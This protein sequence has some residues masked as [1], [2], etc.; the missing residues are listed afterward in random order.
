MSAG[1]SI[2]PAEARDMGAILGLIRELA[3]YEHLTAA[4]VATEE[5]LRRHLTGPERV[6]EALVAEAGAAAV[7][8]TIVGYAIYFKTFSTFL[9][10]PGIWLEDLYVQPA[11][12]ARGIG[13]ALLRTL[14][15]MAVEKGYGRVEW[16]V[17]DWNEPSIAFYQSLGAVGLNEWT[18]FRL[19]GEAL[20]TFAQTNP[21]T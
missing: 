12:R 16:S 7:P 20:G 5:L 4:C 13:K 1:F 17:L 8:G 11:F 21:T 15:Q 14:A 6:A 10:L 2:R 3:E 18:M 19:T 9:A